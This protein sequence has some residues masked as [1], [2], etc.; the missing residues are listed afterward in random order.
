M[1]IRNMKNT[2]YLLVILLAAGCGQEPNLQSKKEELAAHKAE[3]DRIKALIAELEKEISQMDTSLVLADPKLVTLETIGKGEFN[4]FIDLQGLVESED[5]IVVQPGIPGI[6][7]KVNVSE[8]DR[9]SQGQV[10]AE[11][12]SRAMRESIAQLQTN[13]DLAK[14]AFE[15]QE[16]LWKQKIGS[17]MQYLQAKT[18]YES[19]QKSISSAQAQLD[20]TRIKSPINGVVDEV[21]VKPGE[22]AAPGFN[23]AFHVVNNSRM[24][25]SLKVPDSYISKVKIGAPV[26]IYLKDIGDTIRGTV[27]FIGKVVNAM[28]RTFAV[29]IRINASGNENIR[30]NML[31]SVSINDEKISEA[32]SA[33]SNLIQKDQEGRM[34]VLTAE[35]NKPTMKTRKKYVVTGLSYGDRV[36]IREGLQAG[37]RIIKNGY[38]DLVDGQAIT[39]L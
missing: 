9:V 37:D 39:T 7:T 22:Y 33:P 1:Y 11:T 24:K 8:G 23:G 34:Y 19:L 6:V 5:H 21:N 35:G 3:L 13:S 16:R 27:S 12:D 28:S 18:Q 36:E 15:K 25:V 30:P 26:Q 2:L 31:A 38:Q 4:H 10:L 17:E 20:M 32:I 29:E 14:T